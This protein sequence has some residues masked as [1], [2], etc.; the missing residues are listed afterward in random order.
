M[1]ASFLSVMCVVAMAAVVG[2]V[3]TDLQQDGKAAD[4]QRVAKAGRIR[5]ELTQLV[6]PVDV[7]TVPD[8]LVEVTRR[9][10]TVLFSAEAGR[11]TVDLP[12][13]E[14]PP[15]P[16]AELLAKRM[17]DIGR[18]DTAMVYLK[19]SGSR[20]RSIAVFSDA[21]TGR[22]QEILAPKP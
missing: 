2:C 5:P 20:G 7:M 17:T 3:R 19:Q 16:Y 14:V 4:P 18:S 10:L 13:F 12:S 21:D 8:D 15:G 11:Y 6:G 22:V 1:K 9:A